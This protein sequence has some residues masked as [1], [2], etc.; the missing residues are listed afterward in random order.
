M[1]GIQANARIRVEQLVDL[2]LKNSRLKV[3]GQPHDEV[4]LMT[5]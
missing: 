5:D 4:F 2:V 1:N 3:L